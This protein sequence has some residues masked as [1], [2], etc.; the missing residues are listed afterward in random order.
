M[1]KYN[2]IIKLFVFDT[3]LIF[4]TIIV[5]MLLF[6]RIKGKLSDEVAA[7]ALLTSYIGDGINYGLG[8]VFLIAALIIFFLFGKEYEI[9]KKILFFFLTIFLLRL[10]I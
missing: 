5:Q 3:I 4:F 8:F 2:K 1:M 9:K 7:N 6:L 10:S